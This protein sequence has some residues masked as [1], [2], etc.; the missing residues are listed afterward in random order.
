[1]NQYSIENSMGQFSNIILENSR[2]EQVS[3]GG[4]SLLEKIPLEIM[5]KIFSFCDE[6]TMNSLSLINKKFNFII[7]SEKIKENKKI[8]EEFAL[9]TNK[10]LKNCVD[11]IPL[12]N[13][14]VFDSICLIEL[15]LNSMR[16]IDLLVEQLN[17]LTITELESLLIKSGDFTNNIKAIILLA[18]FKL[19]RKIIYCEEIIKIDDFVYHALLFECVNFRNEYNVQSQYF[20]KVIGKSYDF[21]G[22]ISWI[23]SYKLKV[24]SYYGLLNIGYSLC[25]NKEY[26]KAAQLAEISPPIVKEGILRNVVEFY[27]KEGDVRKLIDFNNRRS[28]INAKLPALFNSYTS[29]LNFQIKDLLLNLEKKEAVKLVNMIEDAQLKN[30]LKKDFKE[31]LKDTLKNKL[32]GRLLKWLNWTEI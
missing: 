2:E 14:H 24:V 8:F 18:M 21:K 5:F 22:F 20:L 12:F 16:F 17:C 1:M 30:R 6:A 32:S 3:H 15:K 23:E 29:H 19:D 27:A 31:D 9:F 26:D 11:V 4:N 28:T 7:M 13:K 10:F 25:A